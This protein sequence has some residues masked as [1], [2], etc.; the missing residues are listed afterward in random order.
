MKKTFIMGRGR[1][2]WVEHVNGSLRLFNI[3]LTYDKS[4][5]EREK[6]I[7]IVKSPGSPHIAYK[8]HDTF[9]VSM[10]NRA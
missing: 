9:V 10:Y 7:C 8:T 4:R 6:D 2:E 5:E 3:D 1:G